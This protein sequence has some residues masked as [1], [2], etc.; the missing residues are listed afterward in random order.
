MFENKFYVTSV[1]FTNSNLHFV[2]IVLYFGAS[3]DWNP[4]VMN[5]RLP[6]GYLP[7]LAFLPLFYLIT[8]KHASTLHS[9]PHA[10]TLHSKHVDHAIFTLPYPH[11]IYLY[12]LVSRVSCSL[13]GL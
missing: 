4:I 9:K 1:Q 10:S 2:E 7:F 3:C 12:K 8:I 6:Y 5:M 13:P 11:G